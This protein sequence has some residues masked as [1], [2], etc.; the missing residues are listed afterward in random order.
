MSKVKVFR[1]EGEYT[2][3]H[4]RYVFRKEKRALT[5]EEAIEL[6][7]SEITSI[8]IYRRQIKNLAVKE[9]KENEIKDPLILQLMENQ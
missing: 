5:K 7:L 4:Q 8:G 3:E 2:K 9:L 1:V 6:V